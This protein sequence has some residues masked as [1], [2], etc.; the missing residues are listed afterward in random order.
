MMPPISTG[1]ILLLPATSIQLEMLAKDP[2]AFELANGLKVEPGF[3]SFGEEPLLF[4]ANRLKEDPEEMGWWS[5]FAILRKENRLLG[6]C[7]FKGLPNQNGEVEIGYE[8]A[9]AFRGRGWATEMAR[10]LADH[11]FSQAG[12]EAV[13]AHTLA[14]NNASVAVLRKLGMA[15]QGEL[16]EEGMKVWRWKLLP[17][18]PA[19]GN[20]IDSS[21]T[22]YLLGFESA[23]L[24]MRPLVWEDHLQWQ[25]FLSDEEAIQFLPQLLPDPLQ[26]AQA[27]LHRQLGRYACGTFG[28]QA[29][30]DK[31]SGEFVGQCGLLGHVVEGKHELEVGY[32]IFPQHWRKG[33]ASEAAMAWMDWADQRGMGKGI[34]SLIHIDNIGSQAVARKNGLELERQIQMMGLDIFV[35]RR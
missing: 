18:V 9:P 14:E 5:Y 3:T 30:I 17:Q 26:R 8:L 15:F 11:A 35:F 1:E 10:A 28:L 33:F 21:K 12:V 16:E 27:W 2:D 25:H 34:I 31:E 6:I 24:L 7:G 29:L 4:V 19:S 23:R 22:D 32:H 13:L 20:F